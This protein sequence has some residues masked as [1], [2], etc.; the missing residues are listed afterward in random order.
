MGIR[1]KGIKYIEEIFSVLDLKDFKSLRLLQ[2]G[3]LFIRGDA[4]RGTGIPHGKALNWFK[5]M[6]FEV[7]TIDLGIG[8]ERIGPE[9]L[10]YDLSKPISEDLGEFDVIVDF[11]TSEHVDN[12]YELHKNIHN[13]CRVNGVMIHSNPSTKYGSDHGLF[14]FTSDF[15]KRLAWTCRYK[16]MDIREMT[17]SYWTKDPGRKNHVYASLLK[18]KNTFFPSEKFLTDLVLKELKIVDGRER[19][20]LEK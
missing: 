16:I 10:R 15:W 17:T 5:D 20:K 6:G 19:R 1:L 13:L 2:L 12:Q 18:V 4:R 3:D 8:Q 9:V 11:G 7:K 14:H